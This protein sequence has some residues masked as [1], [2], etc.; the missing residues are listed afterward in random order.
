MNLPTIRRMPPDAATRTGRPPCA[1]PR[2]EGLDRLLADPRLGSTA[3]TIATAL[4]KHWAWSKPDCWPSD[5]T[6]AAKVGKSPGHVQRCM[7]Q[8]EAAGYIVRE[9]TDEVRTGRRIWLAWRCTDGR[10]AIGPPRRLLDPPTSAGARQKIVVVKERM[11][12]EEGPSEISRQRPEPEPLPPA[13]PVVPES[14]ALISPPEPA[15][16]PTLAPRPG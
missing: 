7:R 13:L 15:P 8:L 6:I 11:E 5:R 4:V 2:D 16:E 14:P 1:L 3:K 12:S 10:R 9:R